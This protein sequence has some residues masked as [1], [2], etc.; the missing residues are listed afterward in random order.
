MLAETR[1]S[2]GAMLTAAREDPSD[3]VVAA[4]IIRR[5]RWRARFVSA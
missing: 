5:W 4:E 2:L 1:T 3:A